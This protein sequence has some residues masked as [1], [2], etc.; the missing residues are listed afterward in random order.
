MDDISADGGGK[1]MVSDSKAVFIIKKN[2]WR[3]LGTWDI[4]GYEA[5]LNQLPTVSLSLMKTNSEMGF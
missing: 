5:S 3:Y 4:I 2:P 1:G